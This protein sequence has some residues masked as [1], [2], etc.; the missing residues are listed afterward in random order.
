MG[1]KILFSKW[2]WF[3]WITTC[4]KMKLT[5]LLTPY[6]EIERDKDLNMRYEIIELLKKI[7]NN[8]FDIDFSNIFMFLLAEVRYTEVKLIYWNYKE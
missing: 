1:V 3:K 4:K 2:P 6:A 7:G 5:H 8:L